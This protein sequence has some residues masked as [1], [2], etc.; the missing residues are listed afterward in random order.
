MLARLRA[1]VAPLLARAARPLAVAPA[2]A[3]TAAGVALAVGYVAACAAGDVL[4]ALAL[5]VASGVM[6]ALDGAV[7][8]LRGEAGPVG[9]LVD[10]IADRAADIAYGVGL[11]LLG[12][13]AVLV[14]VFTSASLVVS[15]VRARFEALGGGSMEGVGLMERGDRVAALAAVLGLHA[16]LGPE[17]GGYALIA[18]TLLTAA[19]VVERTV[20]AVRA[21]A[22]ARGA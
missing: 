5:L 21:L 9:A 4:L 12:Y 20:A 10:S 7:A 3:Y 19:T 14:L 15:Y 16:T 22:G 2:W 18:L 1:R 11:A 13:D 17:A 8:R 6:D